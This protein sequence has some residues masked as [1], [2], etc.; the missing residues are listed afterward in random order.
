MNCPASETRMSP[1]LVESD[2]FYCYYYY[3]YYHH[4]HHHYYYYCSYTCCSCCCYCYSFYYHIFN[5]YC[6]FHLPVSLIF[7]RYFKYI[8]TDH[9]ETYHKC[10]NLLDK[11]CDEISS[12]LVVG[13]TFFHSHP[14]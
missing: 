9:N 2:F 11:L 7:S 6:P 5:Y 8:S 3:Y 10:V 4:H 12:K 14:L 13:Q 1:E